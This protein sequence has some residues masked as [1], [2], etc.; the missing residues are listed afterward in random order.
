MKKLSECKTIKEII[1]NIP[2]EICNK[3]S[4]WI[5]SIYFLL[6][7]FILLTNIFIKG[8]STGYF[9]IGLFLVGGLGLLN[10]L[11][12]FLKNYYEKKLTRKKIIPICIILFFLIWS[13][14]SCLLAKNKF[15]SF[16]GTSYR[17]DGYISY[18]F[19]LGFFINGFIISHNKEYLKKV[20]NF[21]LISSSIVCILILMNNKMTEMLLPNNNYIQNNIYAGF[22]F[23]S[24]HFAYYL[25]LTIMASIGMF[26]NEKGLRKLLYLF[27]YIIDTLVLIKN[28]TFGSFLAIFITII[29]MFIYC[30]L[31]KRNRIYMLM[32]ML[33]ILITPFIFKNVGSNFMKI[34]NEIFKIS[35]NTNNLYKPID[36]DKIPENNNDLIICA[37]NSRLDLWLKGI[38]LMKKKP[39]FGYGLENLEEPYS[40]IVMCDSTD[41]PHNIFIQLGATTGI[42]GLLLYIIFL[43]ITFINVLMKHKIIDKEIM[44][45]VFM[46]ISYI[47]SLFFG[48]SM[49][50]TTPYYMTSLGVIFSIYFKERK[51]AND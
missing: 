22:T 47:I 10:G 21:L 39:L 51:K 14:I 50:Y 20:L 23:N 44:I 9:Y 8:T 38:D 37:G 19:Y 17:C 15:F 34:S 28:D 13:F 11:E 32:I 6:P 30:L 42:V 7:I 4:Y 3:I 41:R 5:I 35:A 29:L 27:C 1:L 45:F 12:Y 49:F 26:L 2:Y 40:S 46:S 48:N 33:S 43:S 31:I 18:L 36:E 24:N 25:S 16:I